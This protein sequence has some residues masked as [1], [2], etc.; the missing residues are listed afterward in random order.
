MILDDATSEIYY[1]QLA[2]EESTLTVTAALQE[3]VERKGLFCALYSAGPPAASTESVALA[4]GTHSVARGSQTRSDATESVK[5]PIKS[6]V[7]FGI[8]FHSVLGGVCGNC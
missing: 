2:E 6:G 1:A 3:V 4:V 8:V 7:V 5:R